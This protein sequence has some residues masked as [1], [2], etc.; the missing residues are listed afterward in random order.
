MIELKITG[1]TPEDV[2]KQLSELFDG[3]YMVRVTSVT[4]THSPSVEERLA[5]ADAVK[6]LE[7]MT[8]E[9]EAFKVEKAE[10]E[11]SEDEVDHN[12]D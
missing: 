1:E 12:Q 6:N 10:R 2:K 4:Q 9:V 8:G 3:E 7:Q 11:S 5:T